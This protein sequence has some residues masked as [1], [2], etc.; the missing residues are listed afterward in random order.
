LYEAS[1]G[2]L[3]YSWFKEYQDWSVHLEIVHHAKIHL[4]TMPN[5]KQTDREINKHNLCTHIVPF[6]STHNPS[7]NSAFALRDVTSTQRERKH[8]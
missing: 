2:N 4:P 1:A 8:T 6:A 5:I 3:C 7:Q